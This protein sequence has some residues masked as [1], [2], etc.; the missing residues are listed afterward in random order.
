MLSSCCRTAVP[1][2]KQNWDF[3][4]SGITLPE[5]PLSH[6]DKLCVSSAWNQTTASIQKITP[7]HIY[8]SRMVDL[9]KSFLFLCRGTTSTQQWVLSNQCPA[10]D[11]APTNLQ[12]LSDQCYLNKYAAMIPGELLNT[13]K[14]SRDEKLLQKVTSSYEDSFSCSK[15]QTLYSHG[16]R[17]QSKAVNKALHET[18]LQARVRAG[19]LPQTHRYTW[20][21]KDKFPDQFL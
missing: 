4:S 11:A 21:I 17:K 1:V 9:T 5:V 13:P 20:K 8:L 3:C 18:S 15:V 16:Q 6:T 10:L 2:L 19:F 12:T 14:H 7:N